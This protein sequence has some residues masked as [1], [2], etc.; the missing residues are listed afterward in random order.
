MLNSLVSVNW[1]R[2]CIRYTCV[3]YTTTNTRAQRYFTRIV[4]CKFLG[5]FVGE[6]RSRRTRVRKICTTTY[7]ICSPMSSPRHL[8]S[9]YNR[10]LLFYINFH[11]RINF[12]FSF[13]FFAA[14]VVVRF[15][16]RKKTFGR[17]SVT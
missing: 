4:L 7:V 10:V 8:F 13:C 14:A 2:K 3:E 16:E 9:S 12:A 17:A 11:I 1:T 5:G 6:K 15:L